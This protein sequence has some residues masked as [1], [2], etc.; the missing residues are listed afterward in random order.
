[1]LATNTAQH[2][3]ALLQEEGIPAGPINN[4]RQAFVAAQALGLEPVDTLTDQE[5]EFR[6]VRSPLKLSAT[7]PAV[8]RSPPVNDQHGEEIRQELLG[9]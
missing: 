7:P 6:S 5:S 8:R 3:I 1:V 9:D 2:W 4:V